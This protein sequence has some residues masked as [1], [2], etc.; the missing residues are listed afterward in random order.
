MS[1]INSGP[2]KKYY[3]FGH[4]KFITDFMNYKMKKIFLEDAIYMLLYLFFSLNN[5]FMGNCTLIR[6]KLFS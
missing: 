2:S 3:Y 5:N 4:K 1:D 6:R